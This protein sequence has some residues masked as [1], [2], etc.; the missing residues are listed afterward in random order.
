M[1]HI[2]LLTNRLRYAII[3]ANWDYSVEAFA[4]PFQVY[5]T[6]CDTVT[7]EHS[8]VS[9]RPIE[10]LPSSLQNRCK[11]FSFSQANGGKHQASASRVK[12]GAKKKFIFFHPSL[13][14]R[15]LH[16]ALALCLPPQ[17]LDNY[18]YS[19]SSRVHVVGVQWPLVL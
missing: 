16:S 19:A 10:R 11:H 1:Q 14:G 18:M 12:R 13:L 17:L 8:R 4:Q 5:V 9:S 3:V 6:H 7:V 2:F 15:N